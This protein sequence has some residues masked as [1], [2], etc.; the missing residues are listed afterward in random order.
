MY[1]IDKQKSK[2]KIKYPEASDAQIELEL[3]MAK[4]TSM[5]YVVIF[6]LMSNL[7][8]IDTLICK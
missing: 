1:D 8:K 7:L 6:L 3:D 5:T 4:D 2:V